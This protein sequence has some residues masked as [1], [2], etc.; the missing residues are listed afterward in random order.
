M[1]S[2]MIMVHRFL[3]VSVTLG[4]MSNCPSVQV[5]HS[6]I[7]HVTSI[8]LSICYCCSKFSVTFHQ[9]TL[10]TR[11][12]C[13]KSPTARPSACLVEPSIGATRLITNPDIITIMTLTIMHNRA[14]KR[15]T[16]KKE[17]I[18]SSCT[19]F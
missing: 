15:F 18:A 10:V 13:P 14:L 19:S 8:F 17:I 16:Q 2:K 6:H 9:G 5:S 4:A 3:T 12:Q 11:R 1:I 7:N